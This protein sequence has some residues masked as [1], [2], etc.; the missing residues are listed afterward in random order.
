MLRACSIHR[1]PVSDTVDPDP[2]PPRVW[3]N[4][5]EMLTDQFDRPF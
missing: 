5:G 3:E 1:P 2:D 4:A